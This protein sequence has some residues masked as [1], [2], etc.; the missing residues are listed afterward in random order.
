MSR[1]S[2]WF[3]GLRDIRDQNE[4]WYSR[5]L[6]EDDPGEDGEDEDCE[7]PRCIESSWGEGQDG[8]SEGSPRC[9]H[10]GCRGMVT[11][12]QGADGRQRASC[13]VHGVVEPIRGKA[14]AGGGYW[15]DG[16]SM[17]RPEPWWEPRRRSVPLSPVHLRVAVRAGKPLPKRK[18]EVPLDPLDWGNR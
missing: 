16:Y 8:V 15:G 3:S 1:L 5:Q 11:F 10:D 2:E 17:A 4:E 7:P 13:G 12:S 6:L 18:Y 9:P 14:R